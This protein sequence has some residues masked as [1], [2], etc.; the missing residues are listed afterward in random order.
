MKTTQL[1]LS[2]S[3]IFTGLNASAQLPA[4]VA[5]SYGDKY[6]NWKAEEANYGDDGPGYFY[7][8]CAQGVEPVEASS[9]LAPQGRYNYGISNLSDEDPKT[10]W[11][12][13]VKGYG[14][15]ESFTVKA[16]RVNQL[17]NGLQA[18]IQ[19]WKDNSRVKKFKVYKNG[20]ALCTL[21]LKDVMG[22]QFF[23]L[24][25]EQ[26]DWDHRDEFTFEIMSVY[27]GLKW[28]DVCISHLDHTGCCFTIDT[29]ITSALGTI[30]LDEVNAGMEV[31]TL[32]IET[33]EV[34]TAKA[35]KTTVQKHVALIQI[36][37]AS[38][39]LEMTKDHPVYVEEFGF[40][41]MRR[42]LAT[43]EFTNYEE[44]I[45]KV[46]FLVWDE[47]TQQAVY[48]VLTAVELKSGLVETYSIRNLSEGDTFIANGFVTKT[49]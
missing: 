31:T 2:V 39:T 12:E 38:F 8:D 7:N 35:L 4:V 13:G 3:L 40:I 14:I 44:L 47:E 46:S 9:T 30:E 22:A 33:G 41:S 23:E 10:A 24:P 45:G 29:E 34:N 26:A 42:L 19:S 25:G 27:K 37:T 21:E 6:V 17:Y 20:E 5:E 43:K 32:N 18:S 11:V 1:I 36:S 49:Y 48:E 15:G 28:D 16:M